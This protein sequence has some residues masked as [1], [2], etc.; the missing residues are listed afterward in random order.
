MLL[1]LI[2][3]LLV[4]ASL[5][6]GQSA[7][8]RHRT[9][10]WPTPPHSASK[11]KSTELAQLTEKLRALGATV[12]VTKEKVSQPFFSVPG[13]IIKINGEALQVFEYATPSAVDVDASRVSADGTTVGTSQ[14]T[15]MATPHFFKSGKLIVLYV[16]GNQTVVDLLR[17][18]QGNQFAGG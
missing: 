15:W 2:V 9:K 5:T 6:F 3:L 16:G 7:R 17:N 14:P 8:H 13:R 12:T 1:K 11:A 18:A 4:T 10:Q